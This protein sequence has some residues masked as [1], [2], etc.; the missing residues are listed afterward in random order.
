MSNKA[1]IRLDLSFLSH[2]TPNNDH[3][4]GSEREKMKAHDIAEEPPLAHIGGWGDESFAAQS[5]GDRYD[6]VQG[7][8]GQEQGCEPVQ[9]AGP[10]HGWCQGLVGDLGEA[11]ALAH[12]QVEVY[13][14]LFVFLSLS[15]SL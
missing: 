3:G 12:L 1:P 13:F 7:M 9:R 11:Q 15:V 4:R 8:Q 6:L 10:G 5:E 2:G 14:S